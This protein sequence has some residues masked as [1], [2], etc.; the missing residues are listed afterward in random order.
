M[1]GQGGSEGL[2]R[3]YDNRNEKP[4]AANKGMM[5]QDGG[6]KEYEGGDGKE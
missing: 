6:R 2:E 1:E 5:I 4:A 3:I